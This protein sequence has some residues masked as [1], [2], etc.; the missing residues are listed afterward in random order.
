MLA[1]TVAC[2]YL[3]TM[4]VALVRL[5]ALAAF[6]LL[7]ACS[8][9]SKEEPRPQP[10]SPT[11]TA[12]L[13]ATSSA[14]LEAS[15]SPTAT[16]AP[17]PF[18]V[19][20]D[21]TQPLSETGGYLL[22]TQTMELW[23]GV[24]GLWSPDSTALASGTCCIE[25][26][27]GASIIEVPSGDLVRVPAGGDVISPAW[28]PDSQRLAFIVITPGVTAPDGERAVYVVNRDGSGLEVVDFTALSKAGWVEEMRWVDG[29]TLV[30]SQ[31]FGN[32]PAN[33]QFAFIA[34]DLASK[35]LR[36]LVAT[37]PINADDP[38]VIFGHSS[39][40]GEWVA[41]VDNGLYLWNS[42]SGESVLVDERGLGA[43]EW[44]NDGTRLLYA[45]VPEQRLPT[46]RYLDL[47]TLTAR[48]VP[49]AGLWA[50]WLGDGRIVHSG[51]GCDPNSLGGAVG[52]RD[53][54]VLD[55]DTGDSEPIT[56][57][58]EEYEFEGLVSPVNERVVF[59][60][61]VPTR[62]LELHSID[63]RTHE[64]IAIAGDVSR[65]FH[66]HRG[67]WSPDGRYLQF[68]HGSAHG[69]CT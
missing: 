57:S 48:D 27:E 58:P 44:T 6:S 19:K 8:G 63:P 3:R 10:V 28:S 41:Y 25:T 64:T 69:V 37:D 4:L 32:D 65:P 46:W 60:V 12:I 38:R 39:P 15:A 31:R 50:Q 68:R 36:E 11:P 42:A 49:E 56:S 67:S 34:V 16:P 33:P 24:G 23:Y 51:F 22:D 9:D 29:N 54:T 47:A 17:P 1:A 53:V 13:E 62:A 5:V 35:S 7:I 2:C 66:V 20:V 52:N 45:A 61:E 43:W 40:G 21:R 18:S 59:T 26:G 30:L 14:T 55:L